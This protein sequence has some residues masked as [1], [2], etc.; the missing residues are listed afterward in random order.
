MTEWR[1]LEGLTVLFWWMTTGKIREE[2]SLPKAPQLLSFPAG[3]QTPE[4]HLC[5]DKQLQTPAELTADS[6][7]TIARLEVPRA[8][9]EWRGGGCREQCWSWSLAGWSRSMPQG[10]SPVQGPHPL[11]PVSE[12]G[13]VLHFTWPCIW[14]SFT[15]VSQHLPDCS[16]PRR[17]GRVWERSWPET[18]RSAWPLLILR[19]A[20]EGS[21]SELGQVGRR[22]N[23]AFSPAS[24]SPSLI[25]LG[26]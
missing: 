21:T 22:W 3:L 16:V 17:E 9:R 5:I 7:V 12:H 24:W 25:C 13:N 15:S 19:L 18:K 2:S 11:T 4:F 20:G 1:A 23:C 26:F 8:A 10:P 6:W 14:W